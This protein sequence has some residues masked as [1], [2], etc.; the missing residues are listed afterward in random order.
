MDESAPGIWLLSQLADLVFVL[1]DVVQNRPPRRRRRRHVL[2]G[3]RRTVI[4][5][6]EHE[7]VVFVDF[8]S[9]SCVEIHA[10]VSQTPRC[11]CRFY[12]TLS[13]EVSGALSTALGKP[14]DRFVW[15]ILCVSNCP[16]VTLQYYTVQVRGGGGKGGEREGRERYFSSS[17]LFYVFL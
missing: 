15:K 1:V 7:I 4:E 6:Q 11:R 2:V 9:S 17:S 16:F 12:S 3:A 10:G 13:S 8:S 14:K 5:R